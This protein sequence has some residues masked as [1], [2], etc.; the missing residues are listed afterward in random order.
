MKGHDMARRLNRRSLLRGAGG[1]AVGLPFLE[2]MD[3]RADAT[4]GP[5]RIVFFFTNNGTIHDAWRPTGPEDAPVLGEILSPLESHKDDL[6]MLSGVDMVSSYNGP[7]SGDPH[8]PGM[9]HMLTGTEMVITGPG[10]YDMMGGGISID[11]FIAQQLDAPTK[12]SSLNFGVQS[13]QE[14]ASPWN[15]MSYTGSNEAV[16]AEDDPVQMHERLFADVG[17]SGEGIAEL[18][19][20][21][22]S[23]LDAVKDR[24]TALQGQLG[25]EDRARL[26]QH[27]ES[28]RE[29]EGVIDS[30]VEVGGNC[31]IPPVPDASPNLYAN[32]AAPAQL[33]TQIDLL[34]QALACDMTRVAALQWHG[35][36]GGVSTFTWLGQSQTHHDLSHIDFDPSGRAQLIDINNWFATEFA[37]LLDK[38]RA[39]DEG[40]CSL[41]DNTVVVWCN[42]LSGGAAHSR[43]DMCYVLAGSCGGH[44]RT[45]RHLQYGGDPHNNLLV[46]LARAMDLDVD[47]FGNAAY[48]TGAL[49]NLT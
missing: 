17:E 18:R 16:V 41:L 19:A 8:M 15:T 11:Q 46:S 47:T 13:G 34:V 36:L 5:K 44:F 29:V 43:S 38:M 30:E 2:I 32:D 1:L 35:A 33:R 21:R 48:C 14:A 37:Y 4:M 31:E 22:H 27:L 3:S 10:E 12:F 26:E 20:Q 23:V 49:P 24:L 39:V 40:E 42:E 9:A 28:I 6:L 7:G 25:S 45:G